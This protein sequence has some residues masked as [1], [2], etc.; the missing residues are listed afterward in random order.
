MESYAGCLSARK[1]CQTF[2]LTTPS[3]RRVHWLR[4]RMRTHAAQ[5]KAVAV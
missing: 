1:K 2:R 4:T 3:V 5:G